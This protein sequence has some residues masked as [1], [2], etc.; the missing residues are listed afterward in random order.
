MPSTYKTGH[1]G[2][3]RWLGS[4][5]PKRTDFN[6]DNERVDAACAQ[7]A[8]HL[9]NASVHITQEERQSWNN[10]IITGSYQGNELNGRTVEL[11]FA[12][13]AVFVCV[14]SSAS[15]LSFTLNG[16]LKLRMGFA[17]QEG[18]SKGV[19]LT[20][21]GFT[22]YNMSA[23]PPDGETLKLNSSGFL[24]NYIAVR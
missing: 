15:P 5:K 13:R 8:A 17:A 24:Y 12:P 21:S 7:T 6:D 11:G 16:E 20:Q 4:D 23:V 22:V 19:K 10:A 2:L 18:E 1:L 3:N 14:G 9:A